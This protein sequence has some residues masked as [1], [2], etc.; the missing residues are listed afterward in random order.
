MTTKYRFRL[1]LLIAA[2]AF[3]AASLTA[4]AEATWGVARLF[5]HTVRQGTR[6]CAKPGGIARIDKARA[7]AVTGGHPA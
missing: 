4:I 6:S 5:V 7:A 3:I 2:L 1:P